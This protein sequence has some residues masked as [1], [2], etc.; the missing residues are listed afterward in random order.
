MMKKKMILWISC[1]IFILGAGMFYSCSM[2]KH[3][4]STEKQKII[5]N[6]FGELSQQP[7]E[8]SIQSI[9]NQHELMIENEPNI[10]NAN[11]E[12]N[13]IYLH[14]CG[15]VKNE[16][17]YQLEEGSRLFQ[18]VDL[19]GGFIDNACRDYLN[20]AK[21]MKDGE[22]YYV[23][24]QEEVLKG[25]ISLYETDEKHSEDSLKISINSEDTSEL[26]KLPGI[27]EA[28]AKDIID[29]RK[30]NGEFK[31]IDDIMKVRG[32]GES[33]FEKIKPYLIL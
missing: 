6:H 9:E 20:L 24:S 25:G 30:K 11:K 21:V 33:L 28:K 4:I 5:G 23:P 2:N 1:S 7:D 18:L 22:R 3:N 26:T 31:A 15:S 13:Y 27:G 19:A 10:S 8:L 32:I 16:G 29:Y 12:V 17:V 14:I